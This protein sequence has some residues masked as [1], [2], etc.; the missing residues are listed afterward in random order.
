MNLNFSLTPRLGLDLGTGK[1]ALSAGSKIVY[2][3][4]TILIADEKSHRVRFTGKAAAERA[5]KLS[6]GTEVVRPVVRGAIADFA[7]TRYHLRK[8]FSVGMKPPR[9]FRPMIVASA[10]ISLNSVQ[11]RALCEAARE[12]GAGQI[13]LVPSNLASYATVSSHVCDPRGSLVVD[14]GE[15]T[16]DISV[17]ASNEIIVGR[18]INIG[19]LDLTEAARRVLQTTFGVE[20]GFEEANR[21]K[22]EAGLDTERSEN[23]FIHRRFKGAESAASTVKVPCGA[24]AEFLKRS[25]DPIIEAVVDVLEETPA[26][27]YEDIFF[28]GL[29]LTGG[30]ARM[31][32]LSKYMQ[33]RLNMKT[34]TLDEPE[35]S[36]IRGLGKILGEFNHYREFFMKHSTF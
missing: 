7:A 19:G 21:A 14:I 5:G 6:S 2:C 4:P 28:R 31:R 24:L 1:T 16:T 8:I 9:A 34:T 29:F 3:E 13:F 30:T 26:E 35:L 23:I 20:T 10:P 11:E 12:A 18:T 15:A 17:M 27:L 33:E 32:G 36:V 25:V 22:I